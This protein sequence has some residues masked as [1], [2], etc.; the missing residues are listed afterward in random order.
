MPVGFT[1]DDGTA[2]GRVMLLAEAAELLPLI[3]PGDAINVIGRVDPAEDGDGLVVIVE[4]PASVVL[5][6]DLGDGASPTATIAIGREP[7]EPSAAPDA[8][9]VAG[10]GGF[11]DDLTGMPGLGAGMASMVGVIAASLAVT[12][13][14][15]RQATAPWRL[16]VASRLAAIGGPLGHPVEPPSTGSAARSDP[17]AAPAS[18]PDQVAERGPSVGHAR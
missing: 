7:A 3:E 14:R 8:I 17:T 6:S 11:G 13:L 5:G 12:W 18:P 16:R 15:R 1:L 2:T 9:S 4:L 10:F